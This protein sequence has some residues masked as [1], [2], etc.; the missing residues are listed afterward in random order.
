MQN[1]P[2]IVAVIT[3]W[4]LLFSA[5]YED[6]MEREFMENLPNKSPDCPLVGIKLWGLSGCAAYHDHQSVVVLFSNDEFVLN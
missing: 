2:V 3:G 6:E 4:L 1:D 5:E